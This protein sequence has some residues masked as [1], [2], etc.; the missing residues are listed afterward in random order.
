MNQKNFLLLFLFLASLPVLAQQN[1]WNWQNPL[2]IGEGL[3]KPHFFTANQGWITSEAGKLLH[4]TNAGTTWTIHNLDTL[5]L[6]VI[7]EPDGPGSSFIND[8]TGWVIGIKGGFENAAG[9]VLYKTTNSGTTWIKQDVGAGIFGIGVR[10]LNSN[11][12]WATVATG[13]FPTNVIEHFRRSTDGGNSWSTIYTSPTNNAVLP[14]QFLDANNGWA[15]MD[16]ISSDGDLITPNRIIHTTNGGV[17]WSIQF[18]DNTP[19]TFSALQF[20]DLSNGWVVGDSA[21]IFKTTNGGTNWTPVTNTGMADSSRNRA[22]SFISPDTGWV[23]SG[24]PGLPEIILHTTNGGTSWTTQNPNFDGSILGIQFVDANNGWGTSN[25]GGVA[26]TTNSGTNWIPKSSSVTTNTLQGVSA[27]KDGNNVWAVGQNSTILHASNGGNS[28]VTQSAGV[29]NNL[30][31]VFFANAN[32]GY[33]AGNGTI[34]KTTN[35]GNNWTALT[36]PIFNTFW[37]LH[38]LNANTGTVVGGAGTILHTTNGGTDWTD[39]STG[40]SDLRGVDLLNANKEVAVGSGGMILRTTDGGNSWSSP[41]SGTLLNLNGVA[42][43]DTSF[44]IA[45]G[46]SGKILRTTDG[47]VNWSSQTSGTTSNLWGVSLVDSNNGV[48]VGE[49]GV[50]LKT[51][52]GGTVW[53]FQPSGILYDQLLAVDFS[54]SNIGWAV[55]G[56]GMGIILAYKQCSAKSGDVTG[57]G[58]ILLPDIIA[59]IN[60]LFRAGPAPNPLC[61]GDANGDGS[62]LLTDIVYLINR[63]FRSGPT[64]VK[65]GVCCL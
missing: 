45:V 55:G 25:F 51:A 52:N 5:I 50:I 44:G 12:G 29:F 2:P 10:F 63:L 26:R 64:P 56:Y 47:G 19:G 4:T 42:F 15:I 30:N 59:L 14:F 22:L 23:G 35:G 24:T 57:D 37:S 31:A 38:F 36:P 61:R 8:S 53:S 34:L 1:G 60:F 7:V 18:E 62:I 3:G 58:S 21:K 13:V 39:Q 46:D 54:Y 43:A 33:V 28:W 16:S 41:G 49:R 48:I 27:L 40:S 17:N 32:V 11:L 20:V 9:P 65:T 6:Q